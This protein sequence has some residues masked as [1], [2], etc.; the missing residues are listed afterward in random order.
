ML[1]SSTPIRSVAA[2]GAT[3]II[4]GGG[5]TAAQAATDSG[6]AD[7]GSA[8][9]A[10]LP[11]PHLGPTAAQISAAAR[12]LGVSATALR[13]AIQ[14]ARTAPRSGTR[15]DRGDHAAALARELGVKTAD[16]RKIL[17]AD[18]P[19][20]SGDGSRPD[21][22]PDHSDLIAA[23]AK[24]LDVSEAKVR[25]AVNA[26]ATEHRAEHEAREDAFYGAIARTLEV[27]ADDVEKAFADAGIHA[28]GPGGHAHGGPGGHAH[29]GPGGHGHGGTG[30]GE[31][32]LTGT[33]ADRVRRA[34][35]PR[36]S[37][38]VVRVETD[39]GGV[40]EAH[41]RKSDGT[42]VEVNVNRDFEVTAVE[43][44]PGRP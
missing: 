18:R 39:R 12:D 25:A 36:V 5:F 32:P 31:T 1:P 17:E 10:A 26:L 6:A 33:T 13:A 35:V 28:G 30:A 9:T 23:L 19:A 40:Y 22:R 34:A 4:A 7:G 24:G 44:H 42:D 29:G 43:E 11:A 38:T 16:V 20:R 15:P 41:I 8:S 21:R 2:A 37:G 3:I 27:D 14:S